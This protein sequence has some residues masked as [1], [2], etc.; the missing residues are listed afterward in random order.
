MTALLAA[1]LAPALFYGSLGAGD[2]VSTE[3]GLR[4][5]GVHETNPLGHSLGGRIALKT[6]GATAFTIADVKLQKTKG[7]DAKII[8]WF[9]RVAYGGV[10][11]WAIQRNVRIAR[12][13]Q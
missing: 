2:L 7:R 10:H 4:S 13:Q 6:V 1:I 3:M 8:L 11:V 9:F 5:G 12:R